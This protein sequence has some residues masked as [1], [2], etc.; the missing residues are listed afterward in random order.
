MRF[1][2]KAAEGLIVLCIYIYVILRYMYISLLACLLACLHALGRG[3]SLAIAGC[4]GWP[5]CS[6]PK[7]PV[8]TARSGFGAFCGSLLCGGGTRSV[9]ANLCKLGLQTCASWVWRQFNLGLFL[10]WFWHFANRGRCLSI[11]ISSIQYKVCSMPFTIFN[12]HYAI[13]NIPIRPPCGW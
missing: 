7:W 5:G 13:Y 12:I 1:L 6:R 11:G 2:Y 9:S 8:V 3:C 4:L 10:E